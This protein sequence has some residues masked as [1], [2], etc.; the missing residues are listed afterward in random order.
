MTPTSG[1]ARRDG[2][3]W[4]APVQSQAIVGTRDQVLA[5]LAGLRT[6]GRLVR[7]SRPAEL[8]RNRI[9]VTAIVLLNPRPIARP[10]APPARKRNAWKVLAVSAAV[11]VPLAVAAYL[12]AVTVSWVATYWKQIVGVAVALF[13]LTIINRFNHA[14]ACPGLHCSGC[15]G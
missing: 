9:A 8:D 14:G 10:A 5:R 15:K 2:T 3:V 11:L 6:A 7:V 13:V 12:I 4:S 1:L